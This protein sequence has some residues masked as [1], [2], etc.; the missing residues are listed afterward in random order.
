A[1]GELASRV[2][3]VTGAGRNIGRAIA[4]ELA[5]AGADVVVNV[6]ANLAEAEEVAAAV[7]ALG[8]RA[9]VAA[10]DVR[11]EGAVAA[12]FAQARR[13]LGPVTILVNNAAVRREGPFETLTAAEWREVVSVVLDGAFFCCRAALAHM[14]EAGFG[15]IVNIAG[16]TAQTGATH[17]AHVVAAKAGLIGLTRA[18]ALEYAGRNITVNAVSPGMIETR[19]D[20]TSSP[21]APRHHAERRVPVGR[22]GR[23]EEVAALVRYLASDRAAFVTGQ[24]LNVNGG[25]YLA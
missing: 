12:M 6:R 23:P 16:L 4:L 11:D 13:E 20:P 2:A 14:L 22:L 10:A 19:R 17:R 8:R 18:L 9:L 1:A 7:R 25:L 15:R 5:A 21:L 24:T 3:L